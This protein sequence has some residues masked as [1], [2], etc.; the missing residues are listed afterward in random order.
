MIIQKTIKRN[1]VQ[2]KLNGIDLEKRNLYAISFE[3]NT[4]Y[5]RD[6]YPIIPYLH[7]PNGSVDELLY[8]RSANKKYF[9]KPLHK[10]YL[11]GTTL[12]IIIKSLEQIG[13][14]YWRF[15]IGLEKTIYEY[16]KGNLILDNEIPRGSFTYLTERSSQDNLYHFFVFK[17]DEWSIFDNENELGDH[18]ARTDNPHRVTKKQ[19]GL[20]KVINQ[21]Q[22]SQ[23]DFQA[24]LDDKNN[25]HKT[26]K[27]DIGLGNVI[28][29]RQ[30]PKSTLENHMKNNNNPHNI[31][32]E[33]IGL[34]NVAN[35]EQIPHEEFEN[36]IKNTKAHGINKIE[37]GLPLVPNVLQATKKDFDKHLTQT[38]P[39]NVT[40]V[41]IGLSNVPNVLQ[42]TEEEFNEHVTNQNNPHN[43]TREDIGLGNVTNEEQC[44]EEEYNNHNNNT[45]NPHNVTK[46]QVDLGNVENYE[47][48]PKSDFD[49]HA[50]DTS[51][52]HHITKDTIG[53]SEVRN[54]ESAG[55]DE[56]NAHD[57]DQ[58]NPHYVDYTQIGLDKID[59]NKTQYSVDEFRAHVTN[60]NNPHG[61]TK[62]DIGL[63]N[64]QNINHLSEKILSDHIADTNNPHHVTKDDLLLGNVDNTHD[65]DKPVSTKLAEALSEKL[66]NSYD[67]RG[68]GTKVPLIKEGIVNKELLS[69]FYSR[70]IGNLTIGS[71]NLTV[72]ISVNYP[73]LLGKDLNS[74]NP[75]SYKDKY[76]VITL[77]AIGTS[78]S[79]NIGDIIL[80]DGTKWIL[81]NNNITVSYDISDK[82]IGTLQEDYDMSNYTTLNNAIKQISKLLEI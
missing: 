21:K 41:Q 82:S 5:S 75:A 14:N 8:P 58:S 7:Y 55:E 70:C 66:L 38:N 79:E 42:C 76:F 30:I 52:P 39:H 1:E 35:K 78:R 81:W 19:V 13:C 69:N 54:I 57:T 33:H 2:S 28:N 44:T 73:E 15:I 62:E 47:Q 9:K 53:L 11:A 59:P 63:G 31:T 74:I 67:L 68:N 34:G 45:N 51:N 18:I 43:V 64:V 3:K 56:Y 32:K 20:D 36:H 80:S 23:K 37:L 26:T 22:V 12:D 6:E 77:K 40:K 49:V 46:A 50:K 48:L 10:Q 17:G 24:H 65:K 61:T 27:E 16:N 4:G 71:S 72:G 60:T 29:E 25:P